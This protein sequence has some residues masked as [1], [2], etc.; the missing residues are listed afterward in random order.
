MIPT[1]FLV[2]SCALLLLI[3]ARNL[4]AQPREDGGFLRIS[5]GE[6]VRS[7]VGNTA[8]Y[9]ALPDTS[10]RLH[11]TLKGRTFFVDVPIGKDTD[12][13]R[14][15]V[16][17]LVWCDDERLWVHS[18]FYHNEEEAVLFNVRTRHI[19]LWAQGRDMALSPDRQ[20]VSY[21]IGWRRHQEQ[22][23]LVDDIVVYPAPPE[24]LRLN[25]GHELYHKENT[26]LRE[27]VPSNV[28]TASPPTWSSANTVEWV[29]ATNLPRNQQR[30]ESQFHYFRL[31]GFNRTRNMTQLKLTTAE[32]PVEPLR[33][34]YKASYESDS[35][36]TL[37]IA[38][39]H[40]GATQTSTVKL[41]PIAH[42]ASPSYESHA[43]PRD[44]TLRATALRVH[45]PSGD[46]ETTA[47]V[48][49]LD[50]AGGMPLFAMDFG[51]VHVT[52]A[53]RR[54]TT[55]DTSTSP[56]TELGHVLLPGHIT[57]LTGKSSM[58]AVKCE[59][60]LLD[61]VDLS[62]P[63]T[64]KR[65]AEILLPDA[66]TDVQPAS[67]GFAL[68]GKFG[69]ALI[70]TSGDS[71]RGWTAGA[72]AWTAH[73]VLT[74]GSLVL[75]F[76]S[77]YGVKTIDWSNPGKPRVLKTTKIPFTSS[78]RW[79]GDA[80]ALEP[81]SPPYNKPYALPRAE[82]STN[83]AA[84]VLPSVEVPK[85]H[86][87]TAQDPYKRRPG[88]MGPVDGVA[89]TDYTTIVLCSSRD[90]I[91]FVGISRPTTPEVLGELQIPAYGDMIT[92]GNLAIIGTYSQGIYFVDYTDPRAPRL[93][94]IYAKD[95]LGHNQGLLRLTLHD[96]LLFVPQ[97]RGMCDIVNIADPSAPR[98][99]SSVSAGGGNSIGVAQLNASHVL[100]FGSTTLNELDITTPGAPRVRQLSRDLPWCWDMECSGSLCYAASNGLLILDARN[101]TYIQKLAQAKGDLNMERISIGGRL[102]VVTS[103]FGAGTLH[104]YDVSNPMQPREL[105]LDTEL[106]ATGAFAV[107]NT[108][109]AALGEDGLGI[110]EVQ[111]GRLQAVTPLP[112]LTEADAADFSRGTPGIETVDAIVAQLQAGNV[113]AL[114]SLETV[115]SAVL[116]RHNHKPDDYSEML[117]LRRSVQA[118][119]KT[120]ATGDQKSYEIILQ[121]L[122]R[123]QLEFLAADALGAA[124]AEGD[125]RA[126][127]ILTQPD[128][129]KLLVSSAVG[130]LSDAAKK[131]IPQAVDF[132]A[133]VATNPRSTALWY[134]S[135]DALGPVAAD[136]NTTAVHAL[137]HVLRNAKQDWLKQR[138][139]EP[140]LKAAA[141]G[142]A[143]AKAALANER[144]DGTSR[145]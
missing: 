78:A 107:G 75:A 42:T 16:S 120:A 92:T 72:P 101:R 28:L 141:A 96:N 98:R 108:I 31:T 1:R 114:G 94:S 74:S 86:A 143:E 51:K 20:H 140:L 99:I 62:D 5:E 73:S 76:H 137:L 36:E 133:S 39:E 80:I 95:D 61:L 32:L 144:V 89:R 43:E 60:S 10:T 37:A 33:E 83:G 35:T 85:G 142:N 24:R 48:R 97:T 40:L 19:E 44:E 138:V 118:L 115:T 67:E 66:I 41:S 46:A 12:K 106:K 79:D 6:F 90:G 55:F 21:I 128:D 63:A 11:I 84:R 30:E 59:K 105:E 34:Q 112:A 50:T 104:L 29:M 132:L 113:E 77:V 64:P 102:A 116:A 109:Y 135:S 121:M 100:L 88:V 119:G 45:T 3:F 103:R 136:G 52:A 130:A 56:A 26:R 8:L 123:E 25:L 125:A 129:R 139:R 122:D 68:A 124:A 14:N 49:L 93:L 71:V 57:A 53:G 18:Y 131:G 54:V 27:L 127:E 65:T 69:C 7:A 4:P 134:M 15:G 70:N 47:D 91:Q 17:S 110:L 111:E 87:F 13:E 38:R 58:V 117:T 9:E 145:R 81:E 23:V 126:L 2:L 22:M 82:I